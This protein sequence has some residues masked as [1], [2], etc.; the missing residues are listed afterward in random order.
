MFLTLFAGCLAMSQE[1][2]DFAAPTD[3]AEWTKRRESVRATLWK[4]LGDLPARPAKP[5]V[6]TVS[7]EE[8]EGFRHEKLEIDNGAGAVIPVHVL[9]PKGAGPFPAILYLHWHEGENNLCKAVHFKHVS[10]GTGLTRG[11]ALVMKG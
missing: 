5:A 2:P 4:L 9:V 6:K 11:E 7:T 1:T 3:L 8:R 10:P